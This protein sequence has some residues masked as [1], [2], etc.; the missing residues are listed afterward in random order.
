MSDKS[1]ASTTKLLV[2]PIE[3]DP[4]CKNLIY[5]PIRPSVS[6]QDAS[7]AWESVC[8]RG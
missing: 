6:R 3:C 1:F 5:Y 2:E 8:E 4:M 7:N